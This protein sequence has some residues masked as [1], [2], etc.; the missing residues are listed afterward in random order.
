MNGIIRRRAAA[1]RDL[2]T[3]YRHYAR[4]A[5]VAVADRFLAAAEET[6]TLAS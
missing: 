1:R 4:E 2:V 3:A 6:F 5:G